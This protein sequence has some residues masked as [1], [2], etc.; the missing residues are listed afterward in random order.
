MEDGDG[1]ASLQSILHVHASELYPKLQ[2]VTEDESLN[3]PFTPL[4]GEFIEYLGRS[5]EGVL[6]LSN[7][8]LYHQISDSNTYYNIPLGLIEQIEVKEILYLHI[9]CKDARVCR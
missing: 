2:L 7:Y 4:C 6:A 3:P 9:S 5:A 1:P 8:R